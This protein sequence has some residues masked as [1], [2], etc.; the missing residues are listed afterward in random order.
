MADP[1]SAAGIGAGLMSYNRQNWMW[2]SNLRQK[3]EYQG[4]AMNIKRFELYRE[5]VR[6]LADLT[7]SKMDNY[8]LINILLLGFCVKIFTEGRPHPASSPSWLHWLYAATNAGALLYFMLSVWLAMHAS[9]ASHSFEVRLLT[10][11]VRLPIPSK[12]QIDAARFHAQD[13]EAKK[14]KE[15]FRVPVLSEM[16]R[17]FTNTMNNLTNRDSQ[18]QQQPQQPARLQANMASLNSSDS[19]PTLDIAAA[20]AELAGPSEALTGNAALEAEAANYQHVKLYRQ[21][22]SNWQAYDAYSRVS[23]AMGCNQFLSAMSYYCLIMFVGENHVTWPA[24]CC[25]LAFA[26]CAYLLARLDLYVPRHVLRRAGIMM[27]V[28]PFMAFAN[29]IIDKA[30]SPYWLR[31]ITD[32]LVPITFGFHCYWIYF[33]IQ[34]ARA[35][36]DE[37]MS[38]PVKFRSVLFLD[39][40]GWVRSSMSRRRRDEA[41][42][43]LPRTPRPEVKTSLAIWCHEKLVKLDKELCLW[44]GPDILDTLAS[45][46][47]A[48]YYQ[49]RTCFNRVAAELTDSL[50]GSSE[51]D[52]LGREVLEDTTEVWLKLHHEQSGR[53]KV[54]YQRPRGGEPTL[55]VP[56][57]A[58]ISDLEQLC[59]DIAAFEEKVGKLL[60]LLAGRRPPSAPAAP[61]PTESFPAPAMAASA[62]ALPSSGVVAPHLEEVGNAA[63]ETRFG[64]REAVE[65]SAAPRLLGAGASAGATFAPQADEQGVP[66]RSSEQRPPGQFPWMLFLQGS[67]FLMC[68]WG[69]GF[70]WCVVEWSF[71]VDISLD[72]IGCAW[73]SLEV[74]SARGPERIFSSALPHPHFAPKGLAC[75]PDTGATFFVHERFGVSSVQLAGETSHWKGAVFQQCLSEAADFQ[76]GGIR[77]LSLECDRPPSGGGCHA[78]FLGAQGRSVLRCPVEGGPRSSSGRLNTSAVYGGPWR[79][80][81]SGSGTGGA[82]W[83]IREG[84]GSL[85]EMQP[86]VGAASELL[87]RLQ[88]SATGAANV[89]ALHALGASVA[90]LG[91]ESGGRLH[92]WFLQTARHSSWQ[93]PKATKWVGLCS[94][95]GQLFFAGVERAREGP[96]FSIWQ[97][98]L[99]P[100]LR[101]A[102]AAASVDGAVGSEPPRVDHGA[103]VA[104]A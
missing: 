95:K 13:F 42:A 48:L 40:Y 54:F 63:Q 28:P 43:E 53:V 99:P 75:H 31:R 73:H 25:T 45:Q 92:A 33:I 38:L 64:G 77:S 62:A 100:E 24:L 2:D 27:A 59:A 84:S 83:A 46:Q 5:D 22:Q 90:V 4:Q 104:N 29:I 103:S 87:P 12:E 94:A 85:M 86:R 14:S 71:G 41:A 36:V 72:P 17:N 88:L 52:V 97:A 16:F 32:A 39:V 57:D 68:V 49:C 93:L 34:M 7:I 78:V 61:M 101:A 51:S 19:L 96:R 79:A 10:Q 21:V 30:N 23:M 60:R 35:E 80:L 11:F 91:L 58:A 98:V 55:R 70:V 47:A 18:Q 9:I 82:A 76:D 1:I 81:A 102:L 65:L 8:L 20:A 6:D 89:T 44:E 74:K 67:I 37:D 3:R 66:D 69:M 50:Q 56:S 15:M 26:G